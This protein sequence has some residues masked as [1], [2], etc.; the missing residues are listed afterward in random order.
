MA[1]PRLPLMNPQHPANTAWHSA[2]P[3]GVENQYSGLKAITPLA[4]SDGGKSVHLE[5]RFG[6]D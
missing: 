1:D 4:A 5:N 2:T 6:I 3:H